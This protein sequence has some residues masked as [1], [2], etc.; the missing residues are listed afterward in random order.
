MIDD[1]SCAFSP[2]RCRGAPRL[3]WDD[4][5]RHFCRMHFN[6]CWHDVPV[7]LFIA[8]RDAFMKHFSGH[9]VLVRD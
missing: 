5:I 8:R 2:N 6:C 7:G 4:A 9:D 1:A 3:K